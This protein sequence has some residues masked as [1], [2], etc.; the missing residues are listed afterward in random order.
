MAVREPKMPKHR[1]VKRPDADEG[2]W[3]DVLYDWRTRTPDATSIERDSIDARYRLDR[4]PME[5]YVSCECG[6]TAK[7]DRDT[8]IEQVGG[9]MNVMH[10]VREW[11]PCQQRNKLANNCRA[12]VLR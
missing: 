10:L 4:Q 2:W 11:M 12:I 9:S 3:R 6:R 5:I 7:L 1:E 8:M